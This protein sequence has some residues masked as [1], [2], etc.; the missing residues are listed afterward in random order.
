MDVKDIKPIPKY[1]MDAIHKRDLKIEPW[2]TNFVRY[3]A[4][5]TVPRR[6]STSRG[7][8]GSAVRSQKS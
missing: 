6:S 3:Y 5:L 4:Y 1:I 7:R 8:R 2:Q